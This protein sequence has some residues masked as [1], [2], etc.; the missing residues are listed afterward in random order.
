MDRDQPAF[1]LL[2]RRYR[3]SMG[4]TQQALAER[5][6]LSLR[7]LSDIERGTRRTPY[8]DTVDR[9][10]GALELGPTDR[11]ILQAAR[12]RRGGAVPTGGMLGHPS[13]IG[14]HLEPTETQRHSEQRPWMRASTLFV[15]REAEL[16]ALLA[17]LEAARAGQ[18]SLVLIGGEPGIGKTRLAVEVAKRAHIQ[19]WRVL[20]GRATDVE[21]APP[22][23]PLTE[24]LRAY[25][26]TCPPETLRTQLGEGASDVA[27][28]LPA[29]RHRLPEIPSSTTSMDE[30][31]RYLFLA[32]VSEFLLGIAAASTP[33][34]LLV[35]EDL[36]WADASTLLLI[37]LLGRKLAGSPLVVIGT[38]RPAEPDITP[39]LGDVLADLSREGFSGHVTLAPLSPAHV[40]TLIVGLHGA[41]VAP[42]VVDALYAQTEGNPFFVAALVR[43]LVSNGCD[44]GDAKAIGLRKS[45]PEGVRWVIRQRLSRLSAEAN[46]VLR[47]GA[48]LGDW[49][50]FDVL[51]D[52][53]GAA[54]EPPIG[55]LDEA[56][57]TDMLRDDGARYRFTHALIR[58]TL[59]AGLSLPRR[60]QLHRAA[61]AA[62]ERVHAPNIEGQLAAVAAHYRLAGSAADQATA[63]EY[64]LRAGEAA[65]A[66]FAW[67][68]VATHW[69]V[70]LE[71]MDQRGTD[72]EVC[73]RHLER[74]ADLM[75]ILGWDY[76]AKQI[77]Y[78]E[79][80]LELY[81]RLGAS[82]HLARIHTSLGRTYSTNNASTMDVHR[83]MDHFH[84]VEAL[85]GQGVDQAAR[86]HLYRGLAGATVW[87]GRTAEGL[88][89]SRLALSID[90]ALEVEDRW[91]SPA[92]AGWHLA[93]DGKLAEGLVLM[94]RA[95]EAADRLGRVMDSFTANAWR[96]DW[97]FFLGDPRSAHDWRQRELAKSHHAAGRRR[98][99]LSGM[100]AA[101]A[102]AGDLAGAAGLQAEAGTQGF[103][104]LVVLFPEPLIAFRS[105]DWARSRALWTEARA[106]HRRTGSR[107]SEADFTCWLAR[108]Y[109]AQGD[110]GAA[111]AA[112]CEAL[113][114]G[115]EAPSQ[116]IEMWTR[117]D[118]AVLCAETGRQAQAEHHL[119][120]CRAI[121]AAGE[122]WRGLAGRVALAE[123][124]TATALDEL[125]IAE[126]RFDQALT[127][128]RRWA[129]PW[130][131]AEALGAWG[132]ALARAGRGLALAKFNAARDIY[133]RY[134]A[135]ARWLGHVDAP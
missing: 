59:Y 84:A 95:W 90:P 63:I 89:A 53:L 16:D 102:E 66:V 18:G 36:H 131:E 39:A 51:A 44:L 23:L 58:E 98:A 26:A 10:V 83:G 81:R 17:F 61:A 92:A 75:A 106:R 85:L 121:M 99:I 74:L 55:P 47:A 67:E 28:L 34:L 49:F 115:L 2:L 50:D 125:E 46:D 127:I 29:I 87:S 52:M 7:G 108:V 126:H 8:A 62:I 80:A 68:E 110:N 65:R 6:R 123:A 24:A 70:A 45:I 1:G 41:P 103:D 48:V 56:L 69:E 122:D 118:L 22:Y 21:G 20:Y 97:A 31:A 133:Q 15:G 100:A 13:F 88:T 134:G 4:L 114:I 11:A 54:A 79:R 33:G 43:H 107:W 73:A 82:E 129:L 78:L 37:K 111:E 14:G 135:G 71:L 19:G 93:A 132:G 64:S 112:L 116:L 96:A 113:A 35:L 42:E 130:S 109:R 57:A 91:L 77:A 27:L 119:G 117:P 124:V 38:Y 72:P 120:R 76:Y 60:Q 30:S 94:E 32:S 9:L 86:S 101:C 128:F 105:G 12:R 3:L 25:A 40:T 5:A 104:L